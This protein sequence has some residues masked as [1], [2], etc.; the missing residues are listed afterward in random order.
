MRYRFAGG[1]EAPRLSGLSSWTLLVLVRYRFT[2][3]SMG[4]TACARKPQIEPG[5][6][7]LLALLRLYTLSFKYETRIKKRPSRYQW[8]NRSV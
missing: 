6:T 4:S 3:V 1:Y 7:L 8:R 5:T 2:G